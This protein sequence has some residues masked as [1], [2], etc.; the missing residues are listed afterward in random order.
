MRR[1]LLLSCVF[2]GMALAIPGMAQ[3]P[4]TPA[5]PTYGPN[6]TS[7]KASNLGPGTTTS[8]IAPQLPSTG[9]GPNATVGQYLGVARSA[10]T[11]GKTGLA[12]EALENAETQAL[13]RSVPYTTGNTPDSSPLVRDI[14]SALQALGSGNLALAGHYTDVA[15]QEAGK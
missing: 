4:A 8:P 2:A 14:N 11:S 7:T 6:P 12:Q 3:A 10:L 9:L 5:T 15:T 13:T 1:V